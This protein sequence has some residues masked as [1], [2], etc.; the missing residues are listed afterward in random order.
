MRHVNIADLKNQLSAYLHRVRAGEELLI[1][2]RNIPIAKIIPLQEEDAE[3]DELS[4]VASGQMTLPKKSFREDRFWATG[5]RLAKTHNLKVAI[6]QAISAER[7]E[8]NAGLLGHK[9][10]RAHLRS[11]TS[12]R[13]S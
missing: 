8:R 9:R 11:Q 2:D 13:R 3:A 10:H 6:Q 5:S 7:E 12:K 1:R 4:L